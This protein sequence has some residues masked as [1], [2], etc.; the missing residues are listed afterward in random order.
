[1]ETVSDPRINNI[2]IKGKKRGDPVLSSKDM[3]K[4]ATLTWMDNP[5]GTGKTLTWQ[6]QIDKQGLKGGEPAVL[7]ASG[8]RD[9]PIDF[10]F[11]KSSTEKGPWGGL[12]S[13]TAVVSDVHDPILKQLPRY[14][15]KDIETLAPSKTKKLDSLF[16]DPIKKKIIPRPGV[17]LTTESLVKSLGFT[18]EIPEFIEINRNADKRRFPLLGI[19]D[20]LPFGSDAMVIDQWYEKEFLNK[21]PGDP[22]PG[23]DRITVYIKDMLDDGLPL[24][25]A[26]IKIGYQTAEDIKGRLTW[27]KSLTDFIGST[28]WIAVIG[29]S[30]LVIGTLIVSYTQAVQQKR[31]EIG[32]LMAFGISRLQ[33][34]STFLLEIFLVWL[35]SVALVWPIY[36]SGTWLFQQIMVE[37]FNLSDAPCVRIVVR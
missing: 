32:V 29:I 4:L 15:G 28:A 12:V 5:S 33:L 24:T 26:L 19:A 36:N 13:L 18:G 2:V 10:Y 23:Y 37:N 6:E 35:M 14:V 25:D 22:L 34:Q 30:I 20:W 11:N 7:G 21:G 3:N 17:I 31:K 9:R 8:S 16:F 1:M 27:I